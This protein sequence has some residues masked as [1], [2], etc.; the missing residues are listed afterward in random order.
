MSDPGLVSDQERYRQVTKAY[1][2]L[3]KTI[4]RYREYKDV[5]RQIKESQ[6][7]MQ[8]EELRAMAREELQTLERRKEALLVELRALLLPKDPHDEKNVI[9]E[10]RA[11]TGGDEA[12][13]FAG[14]LFRMYGRYAE[15]RGWQVE[16]LNLSQTGLGGL[17]EVI[18]LINGRQVYSRLEHQSGVHP[19]QRA[20]AT[21]SSGRPPTPPRTRRGVPGAGEVQG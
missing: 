16:V 1:R 21:P 10:I 15:R 3:E 12:S 17:K 8:D 19:G 7:L 13:L 11:G 4:A 5:A 14:E 6:A 2:E 9:L 20:A 18:A